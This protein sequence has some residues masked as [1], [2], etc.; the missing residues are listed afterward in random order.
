MQL[1]TRILLLYLAFVFCDA[2]SIRDFLLGQYE[3]VIEHPFYM[4]RSQPPERKPDRFISNESRQPGSKRRNYYYEDIP[5]TPYPSNT[6]PS[7]RTTMPITPMKDPES[8]PNNIKYRHRL[9]SSKSV[10]AGLDHLRPIDERFCLSPLL[11]TNTTMSSPVQCARTCRPGD[12][13]ICYYHFIVEYYQVNGFA[14]RLCIPNATNHFCS[15]CQCVP[16]DGIERSAP[17]V[18]RQLPGPSI[19]VCKDDHVVIDVENHMSGSS[20]SIHW[21][22]MFQRGSQHYDGVPYVTQCPI[23]GGNAFRYQWSASNPGTHF[24]HAH[25]GLQKMDGVFGSIVV[26]QPPEYDPH[27][28]LYDYDLSTH[29]L[30]MNDWMH[31][32]G[33]DYFPGRRLSEVG[34]FPNNILINGKGRYTD[35]KTGMVTNTTL[36]VIDVEPGKRYRMRLINAFCTV[37]P[38]MFTIQNHKITIIA[39]DG[40]DIEPKTVD[41]VT[42]FAGERYDFILH[43]NQSVGT[44]WIQVRGMGG[45]SETRVQQLAMLRYKG[46]SKKPQ[47]QAP[48]YNEGLPQGLVLNALNATCEVPLDD[49]ICVSNLESKA[50]IDKRILKKEP[51]M[52]FYLPVGFQ[53]YTLQEVFEPNHYRRFMVAAGRATINGLMDGI[54]FKFPPSPP[55]SQ[56]MDIPDN[57]YCNRSTIPDNCEGGVCTCTHKLDIPLNAIVEILLVDELQATNLSHPLHMHGHAFY[58][59]GMGRAVNKSVTSINW[60]IVRE[61][62][63]HDLVN[64]CFDKPV[65]KDTIV[66]P[67][68]GYVVLRF[69]ATNPGYWLFHC[70]FIYHQM[71]GMEVLLKVG[72]QE[73]IPPIPKNFPKCGQYYPDIGYNMYPSLSEKTLPE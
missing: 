42:S 52:K 57:Q 25:T 16:A 7:H 65:R 69:R 18:N 68:N 41:S 71:V 53:Q 56:P 63:E 8:N 70:H 2:S 67:Y 47:L 50:E 4:T 60:E 14:C 66:I 64:R 54:S 32:Q 5:K 40:L 19:E 44:Y 20:L 29:V 24:W 17:V 33:V 34:Q 58:V 39:T 21:H 30:I 37:C 59:M 22:G 28:H 61:M 55:L 1:V 12:R 3:D 31:K 10:V 27:G 26:R 43:A 36:E 13:R 49:T 46:A 35:P 72:D 62:D 73:D 38:G 6:Q 11:L 48:A 45:C 15:N 51:D 9:Q 23:T